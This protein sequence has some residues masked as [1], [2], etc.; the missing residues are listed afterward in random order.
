MASSADVFVSYKTEDRPR[1][2]PLVK[3]LEAEGLQVWWDAHIGTGADWREEIQQHL[4]AARCVIVAWSEH[5]VGAE[6][7][8]VRDEATRA[9][10]RGS[11]V[12]IRLD[13]VEPPL[14]FGEVQAPLFSGWKSKRTDPRFVALVAA[15][16]GHLTGDAPIVRLATVAEPRVSRRTAMAGGVGALVV[17]GVGGWELLKPGAA[18]ASSR[19]AVMS[20]SNMSGDPSQA[21]FSDGIAEELRGALSRVGMEVIGRA[22]S[23]AVKDLDTKIAAAK[24]G[25]ANILTGSVR[26]SPETIRVGAQLVNGKDGVEKWA[27]NYDRAPGDTIKIQTDIASQ[28]AS[29]LSITLGAVKKAALTLGG[30][31]DANAQD[32]Y[33]QSVALERSA[34]SAAALMQIIALAEAAIA[35]D[36]NYGNAYLMK[37]GA[38]MGY[39]AEYA[40][41]ADQ[42]AALLTRAQQS[43]LRAA[44]LMPGSGLPAATLAG[45]SSIR[46]DFASALRGLEQAVESNPNDGTVLESAIYFLAALTGGPRPLQLAD[47]AIALDPLN[48]GTYFL[49]GVCLYALRRFEDA[50]QAFGKALALAPQR[51]RPRHW[52]AFC[53]TL[54]NRPEDAHAALAGL[55][56]DNPF[57]QTAEA[58]IAAR[59]GDR[60][61]AYAE[62]A[63]IRSTMGD[64]FAVQYA[65]IYA[66]LGDLDHAF[67]SLDKAVEIRDPGLQSLKRDPFIDP[68]RRDPRYAALLQRLKFPT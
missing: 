21:Y 19:I 23:D 67:A 34:D 43:A 33:L 64:Q 15:I 6:G 48:P 24:L 61:A 32:L 29:A 53:Q 18:A 30:T 39:G 60:A 9:K 44:A 4:D 57:R 13:D 47:R 31:A 56:A 38:Q 55:P 3:A 1:L 65:E 11:Y 12:P 5:S 27:Q 40:S 51:T 46:L 62:I 54:L 14:G 36:P 63:N 28:V 26:R 49:R 17:A 52:I 37:A 58:L 66:Q 35:R 50:I 45:I 41:S 20:F 42:Q 68:V 7:H 10:R 22:S 8:F 16:N 59:S 25:V 2:M